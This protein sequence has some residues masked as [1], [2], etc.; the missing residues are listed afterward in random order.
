VTGTW[1]VGGLVGE[2]EYGRAVATS[3]SD[4]FVT[5]DKRVGGLI[6]HNAGLISNCY[7]RGS[8]SGV[9]YVAGLAGS[10]GLTSWNESTQARTES[11]SFCYSSCTVAGQQKTAGLAASNKESD[12]SNSLWD[13]QA[14]GQTT[15]S[16]GTGKTT[17]EMQTAGTFLEAGWD[18][19]DET[20]NGTDDIWWILEGQDYP[21]LWWEASN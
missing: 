13:A 14:S 9:E 21:R 19:V 2:N 15:S 17:A 7:A 1:N 10:T 4:S 6:G 12:A 5:G 18:F 8:V 3:F 16:V 11:I 20:A